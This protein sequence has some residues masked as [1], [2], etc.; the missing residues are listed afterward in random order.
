MSIYMNIYWVGPSTTLTNR[1]IYAG[2]L[3][4]TGTG[5]RTSNKCTNIAR[6][7][8]RRW[9]SPKNSWMDSIPRS[10]VALRR[11][12][13]GKS[14]S[15]VSWSLC[16]W[17]TGICRCVACLWCALRVYVL[18]KENGIYLLPFFRPSCEV[19]VF[20][21]CWFPYNVIPSIRKPTER[22]KKSGRKRKIRSGKILIHGWNNLL[23][24][25]PRCI[26]VV[27]IRYLLL[28]ILH[29]IL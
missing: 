3:Q 9:I 14:T 18:R 2:E 16:S 8:T 17:N 15:M 24:F 6:K 10:R 5:D 26:I 1:P 7:S 20:L 22:G 28:R 19:Y 13:L 25:F 21:L 11:S 4:T 27:S 12:T 23:Y 29:N